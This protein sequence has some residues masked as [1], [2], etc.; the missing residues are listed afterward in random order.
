MIEFMNLV[1]TTSPNFGSGMISRFSARWRRDMSGSDLVSRHTGLDDR[2]LNSAPDPDCR[3]ATFGVLREASLLG[4]LRSVL[5][6]ALLAVLDALRVED[7]A[8]DVV[9]H[10]RQVLHAPAADHHHGVLLKVVT[11]A[12]DVPDDLE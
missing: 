12:R 4:P 8:Q 7:T 3:C 1:T 9:A 5:R 11:L 10:A 6:T 2:V